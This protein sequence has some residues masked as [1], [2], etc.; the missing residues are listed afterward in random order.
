MRNNGRSS[1]FVVPTG[2]L[3]RTIVSPYIALRDGDRKAAQHD[4]LAFP[5]ITDVMPI[6]MLAII[7]I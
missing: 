1:K 5:L 3:L 4:G 7:T 2:L 6:V